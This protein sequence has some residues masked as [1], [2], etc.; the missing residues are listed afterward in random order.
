[1]IYLLSSKS[2]GHIIS[3]DFE[4]SYVFVDFAKMCIFHYLLK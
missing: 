3:L 4:H 2:L 1:M